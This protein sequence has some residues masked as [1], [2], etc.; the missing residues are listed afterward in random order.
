MK[1]DK[2]MRELLKLLRAHPDLMTALVFDP[3]AIRRLL[4]SKAA[5][6]LTRGVNTME[7]F[8]QVARSGN[9]GPVALCMQGTASLCGKATSAKLPLCPQGSHRPCRRTRFT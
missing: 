5:R 4:K 1:N 9:G 8:R 6:Q 7:F 3:P 2:G